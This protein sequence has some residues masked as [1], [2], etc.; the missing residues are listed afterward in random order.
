MDNSQVLDLRLQL[1][2]L[3]S[4]SLPPESFRHWFASSLRGI[5]E[6][7]DDDTVKFAYVVGNRLAEYSGGYIA[8]EE[9]IAGMR[10]DFSVHFEISSPIAGAGL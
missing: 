8:D 5:E 2:R 9:L 1:G 4:G 6:A 10:A 3:L 7:A